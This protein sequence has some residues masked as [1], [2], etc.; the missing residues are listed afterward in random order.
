MNRTCTNCHLDQTEDSEHFRPDQRYRGG[1]KTECRI[2]E[3]LHKRQR[4]AKNPDRARAQDRASSLRRHP[5]RRQY[6]YETLPSDGA[7]FR[8][9]VAG[10]TDAE[11][12]ISVRDR[13]VPLPI[14]SWVNTKTATLSMIAQ[15]YGGRVN[16]KL[17]TDEHPSWNPVHIV[18][19]AGRR[20]IEIITE[21]RPFLVGKT[22]QADA[23]VA[24]SLDVSQIRELNRRGLW[25]PPKIPKNPESVEPSPDDL[26]YFAG[27]IDGDGTLG[28]YGTPANATLLL[29]LANSNVAV[30]EWAEAHFGGFRQANRQQKEQHRP[31]YALA[32]HSANAIRLVASLRPLLVEKRTHADAM[33]GLW[34]YEREHRGRTKII[35]PDVIAKR[36]EVLA[37][38]RIL[39]RRG[40]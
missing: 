38:F 18:E 1:L 3:R 4:R 37:E 12:T 29:L 2:C 36:T 17:R 33:I 35:P 26:A 31:V 10:F 21:L 34:E 8:A 14:V 11:G 15:R 25:G 28:L 40:R 23:A 6:E 24:A 39:N 20:A 19:Y 13:S 27:L 5:P 7:D 16:L 30:I 9:Y 32:W 22:A